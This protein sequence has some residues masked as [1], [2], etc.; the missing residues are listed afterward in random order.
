[1]KTD[2]DL[3]YCILKN[4]YSNQGETMIYVTR[5]DSPTLNKEIID[6]PQFNKV[7]K[8]LKRLG[9]VQTEPLTF[10]SV[11]SIKVNNKFIRK[12]LDEAGMIYNKNLEASIRKELDTI[13][14]DLQSEQVKISLQ[15]NDPLVEVAYYI[16]TK[17]ENNLPA[18]DK[19]R[20]PEIGE[21]V[22][23]YFYLFVEGV[24]A[25]GG[26]IFYSLN[27]DFYSKKGNPSKRF[28]KL[29][30]AK[31]RR[32]ETEKENDLYFESLATYA[33][34]I[35]DIDC[36]FTTGFSFKSGDASL[37]G[38][39]IIKKESTIY[40]IREDINLSNRI[41][42]TLNSVKNYGQLITLSDKIKQEMIDNKDNTLSVSF[43]IKKADYLSKN[44]EKRMLEA[45]AKEEYEKA[46]R[47]KTAIYQLDKKTK[48]LTHLDSDEIT[49][50]EYDLNLAIGE[51]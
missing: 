37:L 42:I 6:Q 29:V 17:P 41:S 38:E 13:E 36:F 35:D 18:S 26:N 5:T 27:G 25:T 47:Y 50:M 20:L 32:A 1:M 33:D 8:I 48:W 11:Q 31:F 9:F 12:T 30:G 3:G 21:I 34:F 45:A 10:E 16:K 43:L 28:V 19:Y 39:E 49:L 14:K 46:S 44:I 24:L 2:I 40:D 7:C 22:E 51:W 23:L 4:P 15:N